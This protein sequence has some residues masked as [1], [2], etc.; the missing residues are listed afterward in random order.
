M[1]LTDKLIENSIEHE[2]NPFMIY[3][4]DGKIVKYNEEAEYLLSYVNS[5]EIFELA[6]SY[7]P[8]NYGYKNTYIKLEYNRI[9]FYAIQVGYEDDDYI[10]VRLY[11]EIFV[12]DFSIKETNISK[13][14]IYTLLELACNNTV[15]MESIEIVKRYDPSIPETFISV[16]EFIQ[17]LNQSFKEYT[18]VKNLVITVEVKVAKKMLIDDK[19]YPVCAVSFYSSDSDDIKSESELLRYA[20]EAN[21]VLFVENNKIIIEFALVE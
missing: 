21:A 15:D 6:M 9:R 11:K 10:V 16:K 4:S 17:L 8:L 12:S 20:K 14:S 1:N 13:V 2:L 5:K 18:D 7:A 3:N 19:R